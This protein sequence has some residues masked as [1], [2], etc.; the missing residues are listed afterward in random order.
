MTIVKI[1]RD[2]GYIF[3]AHNLLKCLSARQNVQMSLE[4]HSHLSPQETNDKIENDREK[5][6]DFDFSR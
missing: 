4:L 5:Q 6:H 2:I 3:Q 1:R